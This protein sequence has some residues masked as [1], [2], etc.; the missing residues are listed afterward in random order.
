MPTMKLESF[1]QR[2]E[3]AELIYLFQ[4]LEG[5][6]W[7]PAE[8]QKRTSN[9]GLMYNPQSTTGDTAGGI[10]E[11]QAEMQDGKL[12]SDLIYVRTQIAMDGTLYLRT[13][14]PYLDQF[15][16]MRK[17]PAKFDEVTVDA[18]EQLAAS[19]GIKIGTQTMAGLVGSYA[20]KYLEYLGFA[21]DLG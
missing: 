12:P 3:G 9:G 5:P 4:C 14:V 1:E 18:F 19:N 8:I 11:L 6:I 13:Y 10:G 2:H 7:I 16:S 15:G 17:A 21:V 20:A